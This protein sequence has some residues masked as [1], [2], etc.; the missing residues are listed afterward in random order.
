MSRSSDNEVDVEALTKNQD[1]DKALTL[2][3]KLMA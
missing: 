3:E 1:V 2:Y